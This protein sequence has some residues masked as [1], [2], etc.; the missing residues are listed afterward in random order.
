MCK[1]GQS[2]AL[3]KFTIVMMGKNQNQTSKQIK[4]YK[5]KKACTHIPGYIY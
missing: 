1:G 2:F 3:E 4:I 5:N